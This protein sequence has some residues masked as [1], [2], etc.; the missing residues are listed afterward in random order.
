MAITSSRTVQI[1]V[2]GDVT[3]N[4]NLSALDNPTSMGEIN[5]YAIV[6]PGS[7]VIA[8]PGGVIGVNITGLTIIPPA[9]N[10]SVMTLK[11]VAGDTGIP[12]HVT[13]PTSIAVDSSFVSFVLSSTLQVNGVRIA[14]T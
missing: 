2:S 7:T 6:G 13:D 12:L 10:T 5:L 11:G 4:M 3:G 14:W 9:G 1:Q 8:A